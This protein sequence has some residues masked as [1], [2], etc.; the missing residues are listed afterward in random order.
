MSEH[1]QI[2]GMISQLNFAV[3]RMIVLTM[4]TCAANVGLVVVAVRWKF[5]QRLSRIT[6]KIALLVLLFFSV[7]F[8]AELS[9][10]LAQIGDFSVAILRSVG[11]LWLSR[12][13]VTSSIKINFF[14]LRDLTQMITFFSSLVFTLAIIFAPNCAKSEQTLFADAG[15]C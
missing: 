6:L 14:T 13:T 1:N 10:Q 7:Y 11:S 9:H 12:D 15:K 8:H 4:I 5:H 3:W 2:A